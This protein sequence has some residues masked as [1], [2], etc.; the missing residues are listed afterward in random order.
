LWRMTMASTPTHERAEIV[1]LARR[2]MPTPAGGQT[3]R[4]RVVPI[5]RSEVRAAGTLSDAVNARIVREAAEAI[6]GADATET[7]AVAEAVALLKEIAPR[8]AREALIA[9]RLIAIDALAMETIALARA[10]TEYPMLRAAY[11]AQAAALSQAATSLDEALE[12]R[13]VGKQEQRVV[14]QH[15]RGGQVVGMVSK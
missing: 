7:E 15:I 2:L 3:A 9:R 4:R 10:S 6:A 8:D 1:A 12:R 13:R 14:V 5:L 11:S